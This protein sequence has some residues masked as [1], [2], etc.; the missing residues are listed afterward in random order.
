MTNG[1]LLADDTAK[2]F[3]SI[4]M[5][6]VVVHQSTGYRHFMQWL[7]ESA[8]REKFKGV[9]LNVKKS[10]KPFINVTIS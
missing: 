5:D 6:G 7:G 10:G 3:L 4:E 2:T 9:V 1:K 8:T